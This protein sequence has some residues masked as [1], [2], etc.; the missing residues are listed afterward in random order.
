[1][2]VVRSYKAHHIRFCRRLTHIWWYGKILVQ[3][4]LHT[5]MIGAN[6]A[7][8]SLWI[9]VTVCQHKTVCLKIAPNYQAQ[10]TSCV[11]LGYKVKLSVQRHSHFYLCPYRFH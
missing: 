1:M 11:H 5:L 8:G 7:I 3:Q 9:G 6:L 4:L 10:F 2:I